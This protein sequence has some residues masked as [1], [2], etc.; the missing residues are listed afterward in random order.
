MS[1]Q[2][3]PLG[4]VP[5]ETARVARAAFPKGTLCLRI[6]D[7][8]GTLY[9][10]ADFADL[11]PG[12]GQPAAAPAR[13]A[14]ATVLQ[15]VEGLTDREAADAVR[16]RLDWKYA[17]ALELTDPGFDHTVLSEFRGRLVAGGAEQ[18]LLD[19]LVDQLR[20]RDF[21]K[22]R[23]RQRTDSTHV[24][25]AVRGLNRLERVGETLRAALNALATIAPDW[26][27]QVAPPAWYARYGRRVENYHLP[28][29]DAARAAL[30]AEIGADGRH[31]LG[32]VDAAT[33]QPH[34]ARLPAV[35]TLRALWAQQYVADERGDGGGVRWRAVEEMPPPAAML[36]SPYDPEARYSRKRETE[37]V[38]Y[39]RMLVHLTETC[40][41][42]A[43]RLITH[44][45]T[46]PATTPDDGMVPVV[47]AAL[48]ARDLRPTEHL[49]DKG[50]TDAKV[51]V[52]SQHAHGVR[53][54]G[55][56]A[57]DPSWQARAAEGFD[58]AHFAVDWARKV[59]RCPAGKHSRS[60]RP[61]TYPKNGVVI[62][63][64]FASRDCTPCLYRAQ[65]TR[66][67]REP[68]IIGLQSR[69]REEA[70]QAARRAQ[71]TDVF[72]AAYAARAGIESTHAQAIRRCGLRRCRYLG[73]AKTRL[74]HV[75][76]AVALNVVRVAEWTAG[77]HPAPTRRSAFA[78]LQDTVFSSKGH[79]VT[80]AG[81]SAGM[82]KGCRRRAT[83]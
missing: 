61:N 49:V 70:L 15:F 6:A 83:L 37:W 81:A 34:L 2:P 8:L 76:T 21:L 29:T 65:C 67:A 58:K 41:A 82:T 23:G 47:H 42:D 78:R 11:F 62:E 69:E 53:L 66:A 36:S 45:E 43:P 25:A 18:R 26:L 50:Y 17:L 56:V 48:A 46:T 59:V 40:D 51:L 73:L 1:L 32:A 60:W 39:A 28:K 27:T 68:R 5:A 12:R 3:Q 20:A 33:D 13:V 64:R 19:L 55:P 30:A 38:G 10:D 77:S 35:A 4:P 16:G 44:V 63:A 72:R 74:Q 79:G 52:D 71:D 7:A 54:V 14:L 22:A 24:L 31:L 80:S 57:D 75:V 9:Q